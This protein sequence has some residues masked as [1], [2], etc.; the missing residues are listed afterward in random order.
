MTGSV[1]ITLYRDESCFKTQR[2][3][4]S[5]QAAGLLPTIIRSLDDCIFGPMDSPLKLIPVR[6]VR[7]VR[8]MA[9]SRAWDGEG[10]GGA[11]VGGVKA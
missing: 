1:V 10:P 6:I 7:K 11:T 9:P 8:A 2:L 5:G 3:F 4:S